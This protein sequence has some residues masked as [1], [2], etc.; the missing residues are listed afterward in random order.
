M[1]A[2]KTPPRL[3]LIPGKE[4]LLEKAMSGLSDGICILNREAIV[5]YVNDVFLSIANA[6]LNIT[7]GAGESLFPMLPPE[8]DAQLRSYMQNAFAGKSGFHEFQLNSVGNDTWLQTE[9]FPVWEDNAP[10][11]ICLRLKDITEKVALRTILE[12]EKK[13]QQKKILKAT[14][15][16]EDKQREVIG[17]ELHDNVNQML[18]TIKLYA[19]LCLQEDVDVKN[20]LEKIVK[21]SNYCI[22]EIRDLSRKL[23]TSSEKGLTID[24]L[25]RNL[26]ESVRATQKCVV[27]YR[28]AGIRGRFIPQEIQTTIYRI[29]QEQLTNI[30]KYAQASIVEIIL[31]YADNVVA[32]QIEDNG[33]GFVYDE[34]KNTSGLTN[35]IS[36]TEITGGTIEF[37]TA[38]GEGCTLTAEFPVDA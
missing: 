7:P 23:S 22:E 11:Y 27:R 1:H 3:R 28:S 13:E 35:M 38:P 30:L 18:T 14:L 17:R 20:L 6:H 9:Y 26:A 31:V 15:V 2:R 19:E 21:H 24:E 36:R 37:N 5:L 16:A 4:S 10:G 32:L 12:T 29:A 33:V 8:H 34:S 25:I